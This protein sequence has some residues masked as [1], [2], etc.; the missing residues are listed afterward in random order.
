MNYAERCLLDKFKC[1]ALQFTE[2]YL[3]SAG[4]IVSSWH[5]F[6]NFHIPFTG[7]L[8]KNANLMCA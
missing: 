5:S 7:H 3:F 1:N 6:F 2:H 8:V 4:I